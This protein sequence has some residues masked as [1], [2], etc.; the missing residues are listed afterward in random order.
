M[1]CRH[2]EQ[3]TIPRNVTASNILYDYI[4]HIRAL[5]TFINVMRLQRILIPSGTARVR[6]SSERRL[7]M[8]SMK[9]TGMIWSYRVIRV[10]INEELIEEG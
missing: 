9:Q 10:R 8:R 2:V 4:V 7:D 5:E 6:F 3:S 1:P